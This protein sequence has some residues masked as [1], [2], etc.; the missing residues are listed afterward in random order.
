MKKLF[1]PIIA[2]IGIS[3]NANAQ[4]GSK[5]DKY[6]YNPS[7]D[8]AFEK[9]NAGLKGDNSS[10][11][12][13]VEKSNIELQGDKYTFNYSYAKAIDSYTHTK[14]LSVVGQ[15]S[16]AEIYHKM[17]QNIESEAAYFKLINASAGILPEDYY[18]YAMV[19]KINGKYDEA[20][21]WMDKFG[22]LKPDDLRAKD[23]ASNNNKLSN[24][25]KD[26]G[27]YKIEHLDVNTDAED[28]G[29]CY[30]KDK[31]VFA[32]TKS[33]VKMIVKKYNWTG[34]PYWDMYVS[35]VDGSQLKRPE[36]FDKSLN[37]KLHDGPAS[38]SNNGTNM[39]FTR[40]NY[41]EKRKD[42]VVELQIYFTS[43]KDEKWTEAVPFILNNKE[44][45][46]GHPCLTSGG[47]TMYFTSD[48]PGGYG[49]AD[50][51]RITKD[52]KGEWE[53]AENLGNKINTEGNEMFPFYEETNGVLFFSSNGRFGLGGL[54]VFVCAAKGSGFGNVVNAGYPL[55]T[56]Y[57]DFAVIVDGKMS[58]GYFSS[59]RSGGSGGDDIYSFDLL[60]GLDIGKKIQGFAI[61]I[62][63]NHIPKTFMKLLDNNGNL[64]D[65]LTTK[66]DG[67]FTFFAES[68]KN[69]K[70]IGDKE[71][72]SEGDTVANT[73][74]KEFIVKA[75]VLLLKKE[76]LAETLQESADLGE[77]LKLNPVYFDYSKYNI[78]PDAKIELEKIITIMNENPNMIVELHSY[79]DCRSSEEFNQLLSD[80]RAK[81]SAEYIKNKITNPERIYGKGYGETNLINGCACE[82][83]VVS[84]CPEE[85]HQQN[86]R[87]EFIIVKK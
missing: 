21:K 87:T 71:T 66:D 78:R 77:L 75:D 65:T 38:F 26:D 70:L 85:E 76:T 4:E 45:S 5:G 47:N 33:H 11:D 30:Y 17:N 49:G 36:N 83:N 31:I 23:Y 52:E 63:G 46:V 1:I 2:I 8:N 73:F 57:D 29:A 56:Q 7:Y 43:Y 12:N 80:N 14:Q 25:L 39:A 84:N 60:K 74:G 41:D 9:S 6:S 58:K 79:T 62:N 35:E 24:L 32:S 19:L 64:I 68:D 15:R 27:K 16:L 53:K 22:Y 37:G 42:M 3:Y 54:D 82:D 69:F 34:K 13:A 67:A 72:Y 44:Y 48:M 28:F 40:N 86:R 20:N 55:N 10:S 50:I 81:A 59:N 51:Y 18:N 61:D